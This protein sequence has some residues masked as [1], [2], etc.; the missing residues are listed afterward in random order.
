MSNRINKIY[1]FGDFQLDPVERLLLRQGKP[2]SLTPKAFDTLLALVHQSGHVIEKDELLR[3]VWADTVVEEVNLARNIWTL[4][5][6]LGDGNGEH[7]YIETV[8]KVGYRFVAPVTELPAEHSS[9]M[10]QRRVR[11][12]IVKEEIEMPDTIPVSGTVSL[13]PAKE[14]KIGRR[15]KL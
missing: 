15:I 1:E 8:P 7:R 5:K 9:L 6:L 4:R 10:I 14:R 3:Q 13:L 12:H 2:V 11:A